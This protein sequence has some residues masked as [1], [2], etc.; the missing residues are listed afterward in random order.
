MYKTPIG[1]HP[2]CCARFT[3]GR[4]RHTTRFPTFPDR[5]RHRHTQDVSRTVAQTPRD[6]EGNH[7]FWE[8]VVIGGLPE[9]TGHRTF[10]VRSP[11]P[12]CTRIA[13]IASPKHARITA[14]MAEPIFSGAGRGKGPSIFS[15][16]PISTGRYVTISHLSP[17]I[18]SI[19]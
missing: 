1:P 2:T 15:P 14:A 13:V 10:T 18:D 7:L 8:R 19:K 17:S 11:P 9:N 16:C 6:S 4:R 5:A 3:R 12:P